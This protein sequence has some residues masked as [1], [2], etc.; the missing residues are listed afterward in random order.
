MGMNAER[1][2][3]LVSIG[4]ANID[5]EAF[6]RRPQELTIPSA[7]PVAGLESFFMKSDNH[8]VRL[9]INKNS[10]LKVVRHRNG[11]RV[12]KDKKTIVTG[13]LEPALSHCPEQAYITISGRCIHDCK[14]CPVPKLQG[15]V[16]SVDKI[17]RL[18]E[19]AEQKGE[20]RAIAL[21][22]GVAESA[23]KKQEKH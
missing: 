13:T 9:S 6:C 5:E 2:V 16:K 11:V 3:L 15:D 18:V 12:I 22:S 4:S 19:E 17:L 23:V 21:T 1:K 20:L 10:P 8:R 14:F 7:G